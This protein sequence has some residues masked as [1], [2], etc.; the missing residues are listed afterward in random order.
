MSPVTIR[1][2]DGVTITGHVQ[3]A[4]GFCDARRVAQ[5]SRLAN[6]GRPIGIYEPLPGHVAVY[7]HVTAESNGEVTFVSLMGAEVAS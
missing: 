4:G 6:R 7:E 1:K 5:A 3:G 2:A